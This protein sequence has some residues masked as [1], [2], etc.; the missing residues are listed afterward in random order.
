MILSLVGEEFP[1]EVRLSAPRPRTPALLPGSLTAASAQVPARAEEITIPA[2]VTP[3]KV[4]THIVDYS[5]SAAARPPFRPGAG[6]S[7]R[8][9]AGSLFQKLSRRWRSSRV[10]LT[11]YRVF[12]GL[13]GTGSGLTA[14]G[15]SHR[16][17]ICFILR[18]S[19]LRS[20]SLAN[21]V[22][23]CPRGALRAGAGLCLSCPPGW[24]ALQPSSPRLPSSAG[25]WGAVSKFL[26]VIRWTTVCPHPQS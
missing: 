2:D 7:G 4:P 19:G 3:E 16:G 11:R 25:P 24:S 23:T 13:L 10:R 1:E 9:A 5:G 26:K 22:P 20:H 12:W 18:G 15:R 17:L 8:S 14:W 6:V 21:S